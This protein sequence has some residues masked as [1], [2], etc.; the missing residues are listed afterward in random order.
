MRALPRRM[1]STQR[2]LN[3]ATGH[4]G[5]R[6]TYP[7]HAGTAMWAVLNLVYGLAVQPAPF[8][9]KPLLQ[10][11]SATAQSSNKGAAAEVPLRAAGGT[12]DGGLLRVERT[13]A[14]GANGAAAP[15][16]EQDAAMTDQQLLSVTAPRDVHVGDATAEAVALMTTSCGPEHGQSL[17]PVADASEPDYLKREYPGDYGWGAAGLTADPGTFA[18]YREAAL[19]HARRAEL[20]TLGSLTPGLVAKCTGVQVDEPAWLEPDARVFR[21]GDVDLALADDPDTVTELQ[22]KDVKN[23]RLAGTS[24]FGLATVGGVAC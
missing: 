8:A 17:V 23:G 3:Y 24:M 12:V 5:W 10:D 4:R 20:G 21:G 18:V 9:L 14:I 11:L 19:I 22:L 1:P 16:S 7:G 15:R 2:R 6:P 13:G